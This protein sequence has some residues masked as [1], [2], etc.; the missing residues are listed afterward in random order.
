MVREKK[1]ASA[2]KAPSR[3]K[4]T[5]QSDTDDPPS[6]TDNQRKSKATGSQ[7]RN[8]SGSQRS[9]KK[10]APRPRHNTTHGDVNGDRTDEEGDGEDNND[11]NRGNHPVEAN[12]LEENDNPGDNA[13]EENGSPENNEEQANAKE[14]NNDQ[15]EA[16]KQ[17][18]TKLLKAK[19]KL[20]LIE[21]MKKKPGNLDVQVARSERRLNSEVRELRERLAEETEEPE[22]AAGGKKGKSGRNSK[23]KD[24]P[25]KK[26]KSDPSKKL[27]AIHGII[28]ETTYN[29]LVVWKGEDEHG[30]PWDDSW[31]T[32]RQVNA[33]AK[34]EWA[35][36]RASE[37]KD[38][39]EKYKELEEKLKKDG[40]QDQDQSE[41]EDEEEEEDDDEETDE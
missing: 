33:A 34:H 5:T 40:G 2:I 23:K 21:T 3:A 38:R 14:V 39:R 4:P 11:R 29:Y 26:G 1:A 18:E 37:A 20:L 41:D 9:S 15:E 12:D 19:M 7:R 17:A 35:A 16:Y 24:D 6:F 27:W 28:K 31:V 36:L 30:Q 10:P 25:S 22:S 13:D 32:K 8:P